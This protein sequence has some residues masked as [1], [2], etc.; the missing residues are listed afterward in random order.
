METSRFF[1]EKEHN[2]HIYQSRMDAIRVQKTLDRERERLES[3]IQ[4]L[5]QAL[6]KANMEKET[7]LKREKALL[8]KL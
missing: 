8:E 4:H 7:A 5:S 3:D 6:A 1:S 2:Y